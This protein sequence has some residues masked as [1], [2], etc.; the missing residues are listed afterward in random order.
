VSDAKLR[1][2]I[3]ALMAISWMIPTAF[4]TTFVAWKLWLWFAVPLGAPA[5]T[6]AAAFGLRLLLA[7]LRSSDR[8]GDEG[9]EAALARMVAQCIAATI[10]LALGAMFA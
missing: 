8:P 9:A 10:S 5:L 1:E 7:A 6:F 4:W 3:S 2:A